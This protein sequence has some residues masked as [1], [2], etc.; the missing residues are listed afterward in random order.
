MH[1]VGTVVMLKICTFRCSLLTPYHTHTYTYTHT[2]THTHTPHIHILTHTHTHSHTHRY[3]R[4]AAIQHGL[5]ALLGNL[6]VHVHVSMS[7]I[8]VHIACICCT[9]CVSYKLHMCMLYA[10]AALVTDKKYKAAACIS[11]YHMSHPS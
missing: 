9:S 10:S 4:V 2:H 8:A 3:S 1:S 5:Q 7:L 11:C 6:H